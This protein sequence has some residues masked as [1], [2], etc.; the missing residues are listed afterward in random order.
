MSDLSAI[1]HR[2]DDFD[3]TVRD[4]AIAELADGIAAGT[5]SVTSARD[6]LNLHC[7]SFYSYNGY[8][9]SPSRVVW[10]A[11]QLGLSMVGLVDFDVLD[12]VDEFH[13]AGRALG[14]RTVAGLETRA[15]LAPF[16]DREINSPGEPG[17]TY[18]MGSGFAS[19]AI[20]PAQLAFA[21]SLR[22]GARTRNLKIVSTINAACP[23]IALD[24]DAEVLPLTPAGV[25]TER[26]LCA[27]YCD[28]AV[29]LPN[30]ASVLGELL[31]TDVSSVIA[32]PVKL[33]ASFR[34]KTMKRGGLAYQQPDSDSFPHTETL[35]QFITALGAIPTITWLDG[36]SA[37]EQA[38]DELL[39]LHIEQGCE[40]LN[41]IPDRNWN[42]A[43]ADTKAVKVAKLY[44]IVEQAN[45]RDL[46]IIV[47]TELNAPGLKFVDDFDAPE[48]EPVTAAFRRGAEILFGHSVALAT[49]GQGYV[50]PETIAQFPTRAARNEHFTRLAAEHSVLPEPALT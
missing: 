46:P 37:G 40:A 8:G 9:Y 24:Y 34:S 10:M 12:G 15:Y 36:T 45:A 28:K 25:A 5:I 29:S 2:L 6:W 17:I 31:G 1:E 18:H 13:A 14:V 21:D 19:G 4:A 7:H 39:D 42:I 47:G 50:H 38:V 3:R 16:H 23:A 22:D 44:Q 27:A 32:D 30:A 49:S 20:P 43:D 48:L 11:K 41:I 33:Q 35:N 26:H